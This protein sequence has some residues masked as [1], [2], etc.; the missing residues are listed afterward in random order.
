MSVWG[1]SNAREVIV[2]AWSLRSEELVHGVSDNC[3]FIHRFMVWVPFWK[4]IFARAVD[5]L[6][7][8]A[9]SAFRSIDF[10]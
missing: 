5:N 7:R 9:S 4:R 2:V 10:C 6:C 8:F 1:G 3:A